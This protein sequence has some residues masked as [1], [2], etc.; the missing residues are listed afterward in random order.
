MNTA[1]ELEWTFATTPRNK[2]RPLY[3]WSSFCSSLFLRRHMS[4]SIVSCLIVLSHRS[5]FVCSFDSHH[6]LSSFFFNLSHS[7]STTT[8]ASRIFIVWN[9]TN[10]CTRLSLLI[11]CTLFLLCDP[12]DLC[13]KSLLCAFWRPHEFHFLSFVLSL[14]TRTCAD[15]LSL[16]VCIANVL[17]RSMDAFEDEFPG[18]FRDLNCIAL[19]SFSLIFRV[20]VDIVNSSHL[21]RTVEFQLSF[22]PI[23]FESIK[24]VKT[25]SKEN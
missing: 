11:D 16:P 14:V 18:V 12:H 22:C 2:T 17:S 21:S 25:R 20:Q 9:R 19:P 13:C 4:M 10:F 1:H 3:L 5:P 24:L 6:S 8:S 7:L 23:L 15:D